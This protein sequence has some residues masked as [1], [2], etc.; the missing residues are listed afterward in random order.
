MYFEQNE[1]IIADYKGNRLVK[2]IL[3][4]KVDVEDNFSVYGG[5]GQLN[6][7]KCKECI[8]KIDG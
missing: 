8:R 1:M 4:G 3:C 7:G 6:K 5:I 2:C